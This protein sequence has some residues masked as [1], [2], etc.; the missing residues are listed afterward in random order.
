MKKTIILAAMATITSISF[1]A[2]TNDADEVLN[3]QQQG[4][5]V[6]TFTCQ[7]DFEITTA[8]MTRATIEAD[9][10]AMTDLWVLDYMGETLVQQIHQVSTDEDFGTPSLSLK[11]GDH[12]VYFV[13]SRG[14]EPVLNTTDKTLVFTKPYDTFWLDYS[15]SVTATTSNVHRAVT[16]DRVVTKL[17][18]NFADAVSENA[19]SFNITPHVW[20]YGMNYQTGEP[21]N[22]INDRTVVVTISASFIGSTTASS[23]L[24][25]F[26]TTTEWTT[27]V[28]MASKTA[29]G[30]VIGQ[31]S[32][33]AVPLK[34]NRATEYTGPMFGATGD[35][36]ISIN[37]TW[38]DPYTGSW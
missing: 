18:A 6:F 7:G 17:K 37:A 1:T 12:H 21:C 33:T 10:K 36:T 30:D 38:D 11:Y 16:L 8:P 23:S 31:V 20:Y 9:G 19:A 24:Y 5:K 13:T 15:V 35:A 22:P 14:T 26:S 2:C 34:R 3:N 27:D 4:E 28:T 25:G 29:S 32:L